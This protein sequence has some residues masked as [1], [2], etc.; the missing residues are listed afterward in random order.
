M[1]QAEPHIDDLADTEI[2]IASAGH[3]TPTDLHDVRCPAKDDVIDTSP[4]REDQRN[5][6]GA[7]R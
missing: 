5:G 6:G 4:A 3:M 2:E 1:I 7:I